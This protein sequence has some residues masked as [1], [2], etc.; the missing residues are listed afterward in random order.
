[1]VA[2]WEAQLDAAQRDIAALQDKVLTQEDIE[3]IRA[4]VSVCNKYVGLSA[5]TKCTHTVR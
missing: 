3:T 5:W 2:D 1:M 4:K